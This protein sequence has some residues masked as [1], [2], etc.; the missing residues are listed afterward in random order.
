MNNKQ[1]AFCLLVLISC[2]LVSCSYSP[3]KIF[4]TYNYGARQMAIGVENSPKDSMVI[5]T[6]ESEV[7]EKELPKENSQPAEK[8]QETSELAATATPQISEEIK[9]FEIEN[10]TLKEE[11]QNLRIQLAQIPPPAA[12]QQGTPSPSQATGGD[13]VEQ[14]QATGYWLTSSSRKRHNSSCR[15]YQNSNGK[16]CG[17]EEG[18]PCKI[19]GG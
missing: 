18:I 10:E 19:C 4:G 6:Q 7:I 12:T 15:Y 17:P 3:S 9:K 13:T 16:P 5:E 11:I 8:R 1:S 2:F 14:K